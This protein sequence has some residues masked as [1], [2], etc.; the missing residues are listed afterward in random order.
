MCLW[1]SD[2]GQLRRAGS[3]AGLSALPDMLAKVGLL[4]AIAAIGGGVWLTVAPPV[5]APDPAPAGAVA[6]APAALAP[7]SDPA[8]SA[9]PA[10]APS[11]AP[12]VAPVAPA[13]PAGRP[14]LQL[15]L[16]DLSSPAVEGW[17][18]EAGMAA[19][20]AGAEALLPL[21]AAR[22]LSG[23]VSVWSDPGGDWYTASVPGLSRSRAIAVARDL[24]AW[25]RGAPDVVLRLR[26]VTIV[27]PPPAPVA[28]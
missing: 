8:A 24:R 28:K 12:A 5:T 25:G 21:L 15:M 17:S 23:A 27:P 7:P 11:D 18:V 3:G 6:V 26:P 1:R 13:L 16:P 22:G 9:T 20:P 19:D 10:E 14:V 2:Y 4:A